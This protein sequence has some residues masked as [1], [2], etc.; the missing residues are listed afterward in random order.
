MP[1]QWRERQEEAYLQSKGVKTTSR[2][3][4]ALNISP[5][6]KN[7]RIAEDVKA[8]HYDLDSRSRNIINWTPEV[9][10]VSSSDNVLHLIRP[11]LTE[12][13][14]HSLHQA[15]TPHDRESGLLLI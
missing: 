7:F 9:L 3:R 11:T 14:D 8:S 13:A 4:L 1:L 5:D 10:G 6:S 12:S 15:L 2:G